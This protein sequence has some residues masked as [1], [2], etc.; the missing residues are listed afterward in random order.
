[1]SR[2]DTNF[3][4]NGPNHRAGADVSFTDIVKLFGFRGIRIG[5]WVT[6]EEHQR[7]ANLFFDA[8]CDL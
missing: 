8:L 2:L 5:R 4:R 1:M 7:A 6:A 3:F